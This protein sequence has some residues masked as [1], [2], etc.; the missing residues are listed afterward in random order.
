[1]LYSKVQYGTVS[2]KIK[3]SMNLFLNKNIIR[4]NVWPIFC[5]LYTHALKQNKVDFN[6]V[7]VDDDDD[8]DVAVFNHRNLLSSLVNLWKVKSGDMA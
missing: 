8:V 6:S 4:G 1:M 2:F 7:V 5:I 3:I